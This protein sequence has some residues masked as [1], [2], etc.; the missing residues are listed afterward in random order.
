MITDWFSFISL[1]FN[2][3]LYSSSG[4][5]L[6]ASSSTSAGSHSPCSPLLPSTSSLASNPIQSTS[7]SIPVAQSLQQHSRAI[8]KEEDLSGTRSD[9]EGEIYN[10]LDPPTT[11]HI[12]LQD[13]VTDCTPVHWRAR[14]MRAHAPPI[15]N[16]TMAST[17]V[18]RPAPNTYRRHV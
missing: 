16:Q 10:D 17:P 2:Q 7:S 5:P 9:T 4:V 14:T 13:L 15:P 11:D 8:T 18:K 1:Q 12:H 3:D 6:A